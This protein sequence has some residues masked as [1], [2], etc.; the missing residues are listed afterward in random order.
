M[1]Y[2]RW[3]GCQLISVLFCTLLACNDTPCDGYNI[4]YP[5]G[6]YPYPAPNKDIDT[7]FYCYPIRNELSRD[8]SM[9]WAVSAPYFQRFHEP[10]LSIKPM[11]Q[12]TFRFLYGGGFG[13]MTF[14][15]ITPTSLVVKSG[16]PGEIFAN[17]SLHKYLS[18]EETFHYRFLYKNFPREN[19]S[20]WS[21]E[22]LRYID[23]M[24][25]LY[26]QLQDVKYYIALKKKLILHN[27][28]IKPYTTTTKT[29]TC[30]QYK[31]IVDAINRSGYWSL[32]PD[33]PTVCMS[34]TDQSG[35]SLEANTKH[36]YHRVGTI[37]CSED[38]AAFT[39]ACQKIVDLA[40]LSKKIHVYRGGSD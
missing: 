25:Q 23:S 34:A 17:D 36:Q 20:H 5:K 6:G 33:A 10:N 15:T 13:D 7:T 27:E 38:T 19:K 18:P 2:S 11:P 22:G 4:T 40:G 28:V 26:P 1:P 16:Y 8:D 3:S 21:P 30:Q 35:F 39:K 9:M 12:E 14:I 24:L 32:P 37:D 31:E 29:I